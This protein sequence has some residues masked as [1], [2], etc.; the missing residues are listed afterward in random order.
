MAADAPGTVSQVTAQALPRLRAPKRARFRQ[1]QRLSRRQSLQAA[2][3]RR[4][5]S[6]SPHSVFPKMPRGPQFCLAADYLITSGSCSVQ[7]SGTEGPQTDRLY[8]LVTSLQSKVMLIQE[9]SRPGC[10]TSLDLGIEASLTQRFFLL[11][12]RFRGGSLK[13]NTLPGLPYPMMRNP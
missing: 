9:S 6:C 4:V 2:V 11:L 1:P 3:A 5:L 12:W 8:N 7:A 13:I 10:R